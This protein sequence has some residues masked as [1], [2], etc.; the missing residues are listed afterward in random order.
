[1]CFADCCRV[2]SLRIQIYRTSDGRLCPYLAACLLNPVFRF[3][4]RAHFAELAVIVSREGRRDVSGEIQY[5]GVDKSI[6]KIRD[7]LRCCRILK[8]TLDRREH[9]PARR[10]QGREDLG[11]C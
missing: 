3:R 5:E 4:C 10:P 6:N 2:P 9:S 1:M 7:R 11:C 8:D